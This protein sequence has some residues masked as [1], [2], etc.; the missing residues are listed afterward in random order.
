[1]NARQ[2][3]PT[4]LQ[5]SNTPFHPNW[6]DS[7]I[8]YQVNLRT[9]AARD[10]R[11][12]VEAGEEMRGIPEC[13]S[14][15]PLAN[16]RARDRHDSGGIR[17]QKPAPT[18]SLSGGGPRSSPLAFLSAH[19]PHV[20][21]L[22]ANAVYLMPLF[23]VGL[24]ARKGVGSPYSIRDF[25]DV[26]PEYGTLDE[27]REC[28]VR[29]HALGLRVILDLTPNHTARDHV[30]AA[31]HPDYY[32]RGGDGSASFDFDWSDT[33]K[34]DYRNPALR[35]AMR[36]VL[37]HWLTICGNEEGV[38]GFRFDMAHMI[39]DLT[40][41]DETLPVLTARY[42]DCRPLFLAESYGSERNRDLM[43]RGMHAAYDD[44]F[45]KVCRYGYGRDAAGRSVVCLSCEAFGNPDF[46]DKAEA[47]ACGGI[48]AAFEHA[49]AEYETDVPDGCRLARYTDN[50]D[51]G[52]GVYRFGAEAVRAVNLLL[53][54]SGRCMPFLLCGQEFG[55]ENRPV[56]HDRIKPCG[57]GYRVCVDGRDV[58]TVDGVE[59]EGNV[60]ARGA[61]ARREWFE[62]YRGLIGL[63]SAH[64]EL[65]HGSMA[66][67]NVAETAG[68]AR[69][70]SDPPQCGSGL[71]AANLQRTVVAFERAFEEGVIRCAVNLGSEPRCI[72]KPDLFAGDILWG[73]IAADGT[74][75]A[76]GGV[77]V[78]C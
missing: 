65:R 27:L 26:D 7:A 61:E 50:H 73:E 5:H 36:G 11:N 31:E 78:R 44:D 77:V 14:E 63:R 58:G 41:W 4:T 18:L 74:L 45:Y 6:H 62:F 29:A 42:A 69:G 46:G 34:L 66:L 28:I 49:L 35:E 53:F 47:F 24:E 3:L 70:G 60:F 68:S 40:F 54:C 56:I 64:V 51:E 52:R 15:L 67:L 38:D 59:I 12:P 71:P 48:A 55:A 22:G 32:V 8:V 33:A 39:N 23:P 2:P 10:P 19:L 75:P 72:G 20:T 37:E 76:F 13:G 43:A 21:A 30:W 1:M 57:K 17:R 16:E 25:T 9:F